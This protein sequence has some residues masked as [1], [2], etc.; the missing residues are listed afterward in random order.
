MLYRSGV[1]EIFIVVV[2]ALVHVP[3]PCEDFEIED[4]K[5]SSFSS[6]SFPFFN[7][8]FLFVLVIPLNRLVCLKNV[9]K[10]LEIA[11]RERVWIFDV[12]LP[13]ST[14]NEHNEKTTSQHNLVINLKKY[15]T[16][17][18]HHRTSN[19]MPLR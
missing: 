18:Q 12:S 19:S 8:D 5:F 13:D 2:R 14:T 6:F 7:D 17:K 3:D 16:Q 10:K 9:A 4:L 11:K 15:N 1:I